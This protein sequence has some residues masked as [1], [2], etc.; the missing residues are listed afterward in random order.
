MRQ[1]FSAKD[2]K[3]RFGQLLE[4]S[5]IAPVEITKNG[6]VYAYMVSAKT[7]NEMAKPDSSDAFILFSSGK[8]GSGL[9]VR[10]SGLRDYATFLI[11]LGKRGLPLPSLPGDEIN[12][13]SKTFINV[14]QLKAARSE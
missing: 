1:V 11:E 14:A 12:S 13:M 2:A 7:F 5:N 6:R 4:A 9:A 10:S 3:T 8:I